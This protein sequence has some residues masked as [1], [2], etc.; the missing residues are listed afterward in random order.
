MEKSFNAG[1]LEQITEDVDAEGRVTMLLKVQ[2]KQPSNYRSSIN[3]AIIESIHTE[4]LDVNDKDFK[5][6]ISDFKER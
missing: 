1:P 2:Q 3:E 5:S 4:E 6:L